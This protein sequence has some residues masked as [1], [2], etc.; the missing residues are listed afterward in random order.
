[1]RERLA[2]G[3]YESTIE[4]LRSQLRFMNSYYTN[5]IEG[6]HTRPK[7]LERAF[8]REMDSDER[9]AKLQRL[10]IAPGEFRKRD[11]HV[12]RHLPPS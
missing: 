7:E 6:Q 10:A 5:R 4:A 8:Y 3:Q 9:V 11:V 2:L 1:M 12:G